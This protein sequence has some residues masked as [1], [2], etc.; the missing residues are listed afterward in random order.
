MSKTSLERL[1][2]LEQQAWK[3]GDPF[4]VIY[5]LRRIW[6]EGGTAIDGSDNEVVGVKE[7]DSLE[8]AVRNAIQAQLGEQ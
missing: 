8:N 6:T 3:E 4:A 5:T 7:T 2:E 1:K